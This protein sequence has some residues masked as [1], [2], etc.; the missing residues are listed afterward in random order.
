MIL[1]PADSLKRLAAPLCVFSLSFTLTLAKTVL[2]WKLG[3]GI[4]KAVRRLHPPVLSVD[5]GGFAATGMAGG[6]VFVAAGT[7]GAF[8]VTERA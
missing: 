2:H 8:G 3:I 1:P 5:A 7:L 6:T 4:Q